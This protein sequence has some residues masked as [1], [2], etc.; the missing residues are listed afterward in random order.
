MLGDSRPTHA[1]HLLALAPAVALLCAVLL[2]APSM[3]P[4]GDPPAPVG[5]DWPIF[6][7]PDQASKSPET[8]II[9]QWDAKPP[10]LVWQVELGTSYGAPAIAGGRLFQFDRFE[11]ASR[12][13][14]LNAETGQE[15]WKRDVPTSYHD[16]YGYNNGPRCSPLLTDSRCY[17]FGAQGRL[18][19]LTLDEGQ[20]VWERDLL[21]EMTIPDGFF[22]VGA[23]PIL[24]GDR[25]IVAAGGQVWL[26]RE[27]ASIMIVEFYLPREAR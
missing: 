3:G 25:L 13:Y 5:G 19:C 27:G 21:A 24:E 16:L 2:P 23:T 26:S 17:T 18:L 7:G 10:R 20:V 6:L 15:L 9:K 1:G 12:L 8:G 22:G 4:A 11:A 14:C